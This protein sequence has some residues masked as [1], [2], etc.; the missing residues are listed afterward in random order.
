MNREIKF[1]AWN[2]QLKVMVNEAIDIG[3]FGVFAPSMQYQDVKARGD[4]YEI[5]QYTGL[6]DRNGKEIFEGDMFG[7]KA[8]RCVVERE[9]DGRYVAKFLDKRISSMS[10]LAPQIQNSEVI[11]NVYSNPELLEA[12]S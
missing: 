10:L 5:M 11:G 7:N 9:E 12:K 6:K 3:K 1:R 2:R 8:L 4:V